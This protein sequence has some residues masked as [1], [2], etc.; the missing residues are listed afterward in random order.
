ME[1]NH[2]RSTSKEMTITKTIAIEAG[3]VAVVT[4]V[5]MRAFG[6]KG[7]R[8]KMATTTEKT[9]RSDCDYN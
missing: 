8:L 4:E 5:E 7:S 6:Q 1:E 9:K 2:E 3:K